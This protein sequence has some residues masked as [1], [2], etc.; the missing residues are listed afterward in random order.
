[1]ACYNCE[2]YLDETINSLLNQTLSFKDYIE[3]ILVNDGSTDSTEE[4]CQKYVKEYPNNFTYLYQENQG[5]GPATDSGKKG[6]RGRR[7]IHL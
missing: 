2:N 7:V 1:M 3:V 4:I 6:P 5:Q